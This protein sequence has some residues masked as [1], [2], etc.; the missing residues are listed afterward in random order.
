MEIFYVYIIYSQKRDLY[1]VGSCQDLQERLNRHNQ[2]RS[3]FTK[4]GTPWELVYH[5]NYETRSEAIRREMEIKKKK[6]RVFI[7]QLVQSIPI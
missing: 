2:G 1:Y 5:E 6:S 4:S 7:T 3:K